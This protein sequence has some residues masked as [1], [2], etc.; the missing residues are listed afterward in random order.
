MRKRI[1]A[2]GFRFRAMVDDV[3][4]THDLRNLGHKAEWTR[5]HAW[6][7]GE[8]A[9]RRIVPWWYVCL[10]GG[11]IVAAMYGRYRSK[12]PRAGNGRCK[13]GYD[14]RGLSGTCPECGSAISSASKATES[15]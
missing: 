3:A 1:D 6:V 13:C 2:E 14:L 4:T 5:T 9:I 11:V 10:A 7:E 12:T 15:E 8:I